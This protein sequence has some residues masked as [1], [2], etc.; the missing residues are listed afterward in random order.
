MKRTCEGPGTDS[1]MQ[2]WLTCGFSLLIAAIV[3]FF[4][5]MGASAA[6]KSEGSQGYFHAVERLWER[7]TD[8]HQSRRSQTRALRQ[9]TL[10]TPA[11]VR[12]VEKRK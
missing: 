4:A 8:P 7:I 2:R 1:V 10:V 5:G 3:I 12:K 9:M 6:T 11:R